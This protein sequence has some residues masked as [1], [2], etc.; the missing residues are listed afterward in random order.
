VADQQ[1]PAATLAALVVVDLQHQRGF[2]AVVRHCACTSPNGDV[3]TDV[4]TSPE[5]Q[6]L[7]INQWAAAVRVDRLLA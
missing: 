6:R 2:P 7:S 5:R 3:V 4:T 1:Q